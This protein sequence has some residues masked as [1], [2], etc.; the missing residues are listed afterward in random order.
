MKTDMELDVMRYVTQVSCNAHKK[1][2][3]H[4]FFCQVN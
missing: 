1:V 4:V 2:I 3:R